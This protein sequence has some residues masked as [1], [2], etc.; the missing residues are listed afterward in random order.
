[1]EQESRIK[2]CPFCGSKAK[3][4]Q[5][6]EEYCR[7]VELRYDVSCTNKNCYLYGGAEWYFYTPEEAINKWNERKNENENETN[8]KS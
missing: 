8:T 5:H 7:H 6:E 3:L 1:M 4:V 2:P